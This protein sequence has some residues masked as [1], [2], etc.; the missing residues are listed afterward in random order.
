MYS[1]KI[2]WLA[3]FAVLPISLPALAGSVPLHSDGEVKQVEDWADLY[4]S[5]V[6]SNA[7]QT[8]AVRELNSPRVL[9]SSEPGGSLEAASKPSN[10][11]LIERA[12]YWERRGRSDLAVTI[13]NKLKQSEPAEAPVARP[14]RS[15]S[16]ANKA[17]TIPTQSAFAVSVAA[18]AAPA[19]IPVAGSSALREATDSQ[20]MLDKNTL[21]ELDRSIQYWEA[22]GRNDLAGELRQKLRALEQGAVSTRAEAQV[23]DSQLR[24]GKKPDNRNIEISTLEDAL[25]RNPNGLKARLDLVEIYRN[26]GET[27]KARAHIESLLL[28]G[29]DLPDVLFASAQLY[30]DQRLWWETLH[31]LEKISPV[32]R[33]NEMGR[34]QKMAWAHVQ[35]DRADAL[36]RQGD[37]AA[38]ELLLRRV[39]AE[40]VV[41]YNQASL[42]EPPSLWKSGAPSKQKGR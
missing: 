29:P 11:E 12:Q 30:A 33:T 37:S 40:L 28:S 38:A 1:R 35:I 6:N 18:P 42:P 34:L 4:Q 22:R 16:L 31:A 2:V 24:A 7:G 10:Q 39:A 21:P 17:T 14:P 36:V 41:N 13:R 23:P 26:A 27:T 3:L 15:D 8:V 19:V 20:R 32:S 5:G 25:L 9:A